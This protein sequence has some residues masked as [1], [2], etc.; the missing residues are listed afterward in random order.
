MTPLLLVLVV[1]SLVRVGIW[2]RRRWLARAHAHLT[3]LIKPPRPIF[4]GHDESKHSEA[5]RP[6]RRAD[7]LRTDAVRV[8][9]QEPSPSRIHLVGRG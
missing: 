2:G 9:L 7:S 5:M 1:I 3:Q 8:E 4:T 6:R